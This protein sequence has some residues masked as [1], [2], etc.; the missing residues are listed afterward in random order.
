MP[1]P[2]PVLTFANKTD[3]NEGK[4]N[5]DESSGVFAK[6][7]FDGGE[8]SAYVV[9]DFLHS[10]SI[11]WGFKGIDVAAGLSCRFVHSGPEIRSGR[12]ENNLD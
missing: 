4:E 8:C 9:D 10:N 5:G 6:A 7:F 2:R 12:Q 3:G 11:V 1:I